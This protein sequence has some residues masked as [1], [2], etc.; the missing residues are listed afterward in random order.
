MRI[1]TIRGGKI[2]FM[3]FILNQKRKITSCLLSSLR[4]PLWI[5][6]PPGPDYH[7]QQAQAGSSGSLQHENRLDIGPPVLNCGT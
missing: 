2:N 6:D 5:P 1:P 7:A 3:K 4:P